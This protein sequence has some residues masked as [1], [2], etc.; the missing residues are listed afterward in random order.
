[1]KWMNGVD[2][3][4]YQGGINLHKVAGDFVI[5]KATQGTTYTN[6]FW[7]RQ[8]ASA[9]T[10]GKLIGF[11]HYATG[12]GAAEEAA[13][14]LKTVKNYIGKAILC[15]DWEQGSNKAWGNVNYCKTL[16]D[17]VKEGSHV[18]PFLYIQQSACQ[19]FSKIAGI[20]EFPLWVAQYYN[21]DMG[22]D[23]YLSNFR[24]V[25]DIR[26]WK[27]PA[28]RQYSPSGRLSGW[29][30]ALDLDAAYMTRDA[31][32]KYAAVITDGAKQENKTTASGT[33]QEEKTVE[34]KA[35]PSY[36]IGAYDLHDIAYGST[37]E[38]VKHA[39]RLLTQLGYQVGAIDGVCGSKTYAALC[40]FQEKK[41]LSAV[42][43]GT[44]RA[45]MQECG[46]ATK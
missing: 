20:T 39:Q 25:K 44:W 4:S 26:P 27:N 28:I 8:A 24:T 6:P 19:Q 29:T 1:M 30:G 31:W 34:T 38:A 16:L 36:K 11:Y 41:H 10:A 46:L 12:A 33:K 35:D 32:S 15:I 22:K 14:F 23:G 37:G 9:L 13:F 2:I 42:G 7:K 18:T 43:K 3:S 21:A 5:I 45:L 40:D 17:N